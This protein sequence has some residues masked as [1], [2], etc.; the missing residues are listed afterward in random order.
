M[1]AKTIGGKPKK[2][3]SIDFDY[4]QIVDMETMNDYPDGRDN[5]PF[6]SEIVWTHRYA[7][8]PALFDVGFNESEYEKLL[9]LLENQNNKT[10]VLI[11]YSHKDIYD[12]I[13]EVCPSD[14]P[15]EVVNI[16]MHHDYSNANEELDC[17]NW[18][19]HL[20]QEYKTFKWR[21]IA[22]PVSTEMYEAHELDNL[23]STSINTS[24]EKEKYDAIFLC[25][26]DTWLPPHLD[27]RFENLLKYFA[28]VFNSV[29][30]SNLVMSPR[31]VTREECERLAK[32]QAK[33]LEQY[34]AAH[35]KKPK[36]MI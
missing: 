12:F 31:N 34:R 16:D 8:R 10:P 3:L 29:K 20:Q 27:S 35:L 2:V 28:N 26:S 14:S 36:S 21:W 25:R 18:V 32:E 11:S 13:H 19:S 30:A 4:F 6:L 17:G 22:N 1:K 15:L 23:I 7:E 33:F 9:S 5:T 24:L